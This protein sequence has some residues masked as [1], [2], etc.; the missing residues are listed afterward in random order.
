MQYS[1]II[2]AILYG[3]L[4]FDEQVDSATIIGTAVIIAAGVYIV[5]REDQPSV[6]KNR[7]VLE[8]RSRFDTGIVPRVGL[9]LRLFDRR[10]N[11]QT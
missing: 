11:G 9:W 10:K 1:Q 5:L 6:S 8:N 7:P 2:W 3:Y 4:I